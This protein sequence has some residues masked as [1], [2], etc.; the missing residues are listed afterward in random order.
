ME[1]DKLNIILQLFCQNANSH[2]T[3]VS[4]IAYNLY[5]AVY[6]DFKMKSRTVGRNI[7]KPVFVS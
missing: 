1:K 4:G 2:L 6:E 5:A 3:S 7:N